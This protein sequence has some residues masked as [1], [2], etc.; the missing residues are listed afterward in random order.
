MSKL[1]TF[2]F[3][4][5]QWFWVRLA[6]IQ[7]DGKHVGWGLLGLVAPMT[8]WTYWPRPKLHTTK[9]VK[10]FLKRWEDEFYNRVM[11]DLADPLLESIAEAEDQE[12]LHA[13]WNKIGGKPM[14]KDLTIKTL[15]QALMDLYRC[16]TDPGSR[17]RLWPI[18]ETRELLTELGYLRSNGQRTEAGRELQEGE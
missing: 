11:D 8:G 12:F 7:R 13:V 4:V 2:N 14:D 10:N 17:G 5:L 9:R 1:G 18:K 16:M 15:S 3:L 6:D